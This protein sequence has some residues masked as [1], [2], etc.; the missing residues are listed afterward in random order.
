MPH[1]T[2]RRSEKRRDAPTDLDAAMMNRA[3]ALARRGEGRVEPNPM[4]G[5]VIARG[6]TVM[7]E[8][9]HR[10]F[11]G[12]HAEVAAL[13]A[14]RAAPR[15]ATLYVTL[16]PCT[17][18]GKTPPCVDAILRAGLARVVVGVRDPNPQVNGRG[19]RRLRRAGVLVDVGIAEPGACAALAPFLTRQC[20]HRPYV[21][22]KWAQTL[23]GKLATRTGDSQWISGEASRRL[24][25]RLRARVDA[26][27]V[28]SGTALRDD[29]QLTARGVP[30][31]RT[32][33][34]VVVDGRLRLRRSSRLVRTAPTP[35]VIVL[36]T[37]ERAQ[38][39]KAGQLR[40]LGVTVT[41][42]GSRQG[43]LSPRACLRA[44][45]AHDM[46]NVLLEGGPTLL[47]AFF[48]ADLVDEAWVFTAP[49]LLG[50]EGAPQTL[51]DPKARRMRDARRPEVIAVRHLEG[52]TLHRLRFHQPPV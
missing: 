42:I 15:G 29:P 27:I 50:D 30:L 41:G 18:V 37:R 4:V 16:E 21:I 8:G 23:D 14:C 48:R 43:R 36:T 7:G 22:A 26:V 40:A 44:L 47:G 5:C 39:R 49:F 51:F 24:V 2:N 10:R 25:H 34:R 45:T 20:R 28:G 12:A 3:I 38:S 17:H 9:Y 11:G 13:A 33:A 19:I 31:R 32:A 35:P 6:T 1:R 52:D 46:T